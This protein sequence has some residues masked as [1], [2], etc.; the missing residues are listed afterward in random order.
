MSPLPLPGKDPQM[1]LRPN[2]LKTLA[3]RLLCIIHDGTEIIDKPATP[4]RLTLQ[5]FESEM[6]VALLECVNCSILRNLPQ[7][8]DFVNKCGEYSQGNN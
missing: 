4:P 1:A 6:I 8:I 2:R 5:A 3:H 7:G